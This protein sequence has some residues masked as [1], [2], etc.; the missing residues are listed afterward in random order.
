MN[1][2]SNQA[3]G[4]S[5]GKLILTTAILS[6][7]FTA[8]IG[9]IAIPMMGTNL[10]EKEAVETVEVDENIIVAAAGLV[11]RSVSKRMS[12]G[13]PRDSFSYLFQPS[14]DRNSMWSNPYTNTNTNNTTTTNSNRNT[15]TY[16]GTCTGTDMDSAPLMN[17][18]TSALLGEID[19]DE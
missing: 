4:E 19:E 18:V 17:D 1:D 16:T 7:I 8:P 12:L 6:V 13:S 2:D 5:Y 14:R 10:L 3:T 9:A 15:F 11:V